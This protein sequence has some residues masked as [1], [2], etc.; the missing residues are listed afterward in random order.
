[1][2]VKAFI[3]KSSR[4]LCHLLLILPHSLSQPPPTRIFNNNSLKFSSRV[5]CLNPSQTTCQLYILIFAHTNNF[6]TYICMYVCIIIE[7]IFCHDLAISWTICAHI[8]CM[9]IHPQPIFPG[10]SNRKYI[11]SMIYQNGGVDCS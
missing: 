10:L 6:A 4:I 8:L 11:I 9:H 1:M 2:S 3:F 7:Q 5:V